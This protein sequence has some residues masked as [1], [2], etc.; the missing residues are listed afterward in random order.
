MNSE[1]CLA[2]GL[3]ASKR[4]E[5]PAYSADF[6]LYVVAAMIDRKEDQEDFARRR[7]FQST[8]FVGLKAEND[9]D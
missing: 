6:A 5:F 3:P 4:A 2:E 7:K 9:Q 8:V 1:R